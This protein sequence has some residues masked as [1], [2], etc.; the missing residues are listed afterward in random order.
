MASIVVNDSRVGRDTGI[1]LGI[2]DS[3]WVR[4]EGSIH[5]TTSRATAV[6]GGGGN[7]ILN[8]GTIRGHHGIHF[9]GTLINNGEVSGTYHAFDEFSGTAVIGGGGNNVIVNNGRMEGTFAAARLGLGSDVFDARL[10]I[11]EE[12]FGEA[13]ND[14]LLGGSFR[15]LLFG[16][17]DNDQL[18]G[19]SGA[20]SLD[21]GNG[22]DYAR[23]DLAATAVTLSLVDPSANTGEA[24]GDTFVGIEGLYGSGFGDTLIGNDVANTILGLGGNDAIAGGLGVDMLYGNDGADIIFGGADGDLITGGAGGDVLKGEG[25]ADLFVFNAGDNGDLILD[26]NAGGIHDGFDLR[27]Y[28]DASG[29]TGN[30]P[31]AAGILQ[32]YQNGADTDVYLQGAFAFRIQNV[33]A[34][35]I[36]DTYFLFQ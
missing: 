17:E 1:S 30:D 5:D 12:V 6:V 21:G 32:I 16:G 20:D 35:A 31:R 14:T 18:M 29:F 11:Q 22:F 2:G 27:G 10:G 15:D 26:L 33:V 23:Y 4:S 28:F 36:D 34:A 9:S 13:G 25:G 3:L 19:G 7:T 8:D 24:A